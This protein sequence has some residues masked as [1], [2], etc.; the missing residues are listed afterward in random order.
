MSTLK[1]V[2]ESPLDKEKK[3]ELETLD[4]VLELNETVGSEIFN[5]LIEENDIE[6]I[7]PKI[8]SLIDILEPLTLQ[9]L[10]IANYEN[11]VINL[12]WP[13]ITEPVFET[14]TCFPKSYYT[15]NNKERLILAYAENF[16]RQFQFHYKMRKPL[17]LQAPNECGL[18]VIS[19]P[20]TN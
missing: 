19:C 10:N 11:G 4:T 15:N 13:E 18:Q 20:S 5:R 14:R 8:F 16:R 6:E 7:P 9:S 2:S 12:C 1:V 3:G 17:L